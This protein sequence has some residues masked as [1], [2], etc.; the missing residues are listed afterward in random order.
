METCSYTLLLGNKSVGSQVVRT[1]VTE[2]TT[3]LEAK[4]LFGGVLGQGTLNQTSQLLSSSLESLRFT[5]EEDSRG[6]RRSFEVLFDARSGLVRATRRSGQLLERAETPYL[7]PYSDPLGLLH[8]LRR[9]LDMGASG[10]G[11]ARVPML[12]KDVV[13]EPLG[14]S[15]IET[16]LGRHTTVGYL[17]VPGPGYVY[18]DAQ[19]PHALVRLVQPT[20]HGLVEAF[21]TRIVQEDSAQVTTPNT[22]PEARAPKRRRRGG[23]KR[24]RVEP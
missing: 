23:R 24:R 12:G 17:L 3:T 6:E 5:E 8:R 16:A 22:A 11:T 7:R 9:R 13:I 1:T 18:V 14:A 15:E 20:E 21:L 2:R 4:A 10:T 19:P